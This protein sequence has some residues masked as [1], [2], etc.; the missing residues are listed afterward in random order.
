MFANTISVTI[1]ADAARVLTRINQDSFGSTYR[2]ATATEFTEL[3]IRNSS[4]NEGGVLVDRH[5]AEL[6]HTVYALS[7]G[8]APEKFYAASTTFRTRRQSGDPTRLADVEK[9]LNTV[10]NSTLVSGMVQGES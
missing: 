5:N 8:S 4:G 6:R 1:G 7:D 2:L 3:V 9:A 10:V